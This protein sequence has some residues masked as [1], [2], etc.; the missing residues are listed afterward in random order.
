[1]WKSKNKTCSSHTFEF[2]YLHHTFLE[3][4]VPQSEINFIYF[5][6]YFC[7]PIFSI[8]SRVS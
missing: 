8:V 7:A 2:C 5:M 3:T 1:M 6:T 4:P